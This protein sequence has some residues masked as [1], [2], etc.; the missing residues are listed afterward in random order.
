MS[1]IKRFLKSPIGLVLFSVVLVFLALIQLFPS[2]GET[3]HVSFIMLGAFVWMLVIPLT[4]VRFILK[5]KFESYGWRLPE[6][7]RRAILLTLFSII[8]LVPV[9]IF[10]GTQESFQK[11][12]TLQDTSL[13]NFLLMSVV[14]SFIYYTSEEFLFRGFLF[15]G[16]WRKVGYHSF[17]ITSLVFALFHVTKPLLEIPFAFFASVLLCYLS[18]KTKSFIP[19]FV[20]HFTIALVLNVLVTFVWG[21]PALG[22]NSFHF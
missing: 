14:L 18:F 16:L 21:A 13:E 4:V 10:F 5:E 17:W 6:D 20:V 8:I 15:W 2:R 12:Y 7:K 19:A 1:I 11:F 22:G 9:M 3:L